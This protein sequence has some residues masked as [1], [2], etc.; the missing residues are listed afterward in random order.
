MQA[1]MQ[2]IQ[3]DTEAVDLDAELN[4]TVKREQVLKGELAAE[5]GLPIV[6]A[7]LFSTPH[8]LEPH[9]VQSRVTAR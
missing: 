3:H 2:Q 8:A 7:P 4:S 1:Q 6:K 5:K 9:N